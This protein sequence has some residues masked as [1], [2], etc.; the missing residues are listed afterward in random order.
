MGAYQ[1]CS[2]FPVNTMQVDQLPALAAYIH[3]SLPVDM[4]QNQLKVCIPMTYACKAGS[5]LSD[6]I[7]SL[8]TCWI[9]QMSN[10]KVSIQ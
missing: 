10:K 4:L 8:K 3:L 7:C 6:V 2:P 9:N 1:S 5:D